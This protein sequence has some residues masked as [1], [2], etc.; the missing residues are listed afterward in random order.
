MYEFFAWSLHVD[1]SFVLSASQTK[2][3]HPKRIA[4]NLGQFS[5]N[6]GKFYQLRA[7]VTTGLLFLSSVVTSSL[8]FTFLLVG[9]FSLTFPQENCPNQRWESAGSPRWRD[10]F[11]QFRTPSPECWFGF[12]QRQS[13][14]GPIRSSRR[15]GKASSVR[16]APRLA[17][18][19]DI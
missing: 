15:D 16:D 13:P 9:P 19:L 17:S 4:V 5:G 1:L 11:C 3:C 12:G 8:T 10:T 18:R 14:G 7:P 6:T 2:R